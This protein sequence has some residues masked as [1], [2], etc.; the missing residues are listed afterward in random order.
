VDDELQALVVSLIPQVKAI[1][2]RYYIKAPHAL[3]R[4][5]LESIAFT[6]ATSSS[7]MAPA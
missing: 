1:A 3:E 5:E 4:D 2:W 7:Q 6:G